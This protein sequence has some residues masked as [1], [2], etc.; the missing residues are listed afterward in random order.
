LAEQTKNDFLGR[1]WS[2]PPSFDINSAG[3]EMTEAEDDI[4]KSLEILLST[5]TGERVMQPEYGCDLSEMVFEPLDTTLKTYITDK[6]KTA[7]A[8]Y[9]PRISLLKVDLAP[10]QSNGEYVLI[11]VSYYV[12]NT[13]SRNNIVYPYYIGEA[14]ERR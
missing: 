2:F 13:N 9:E 3:L 8:L 4:K 12:R 11:D 1:G 5:A 6:I 14:T 10:E 7:I